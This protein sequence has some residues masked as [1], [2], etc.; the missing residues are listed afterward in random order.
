MQ[1]SSAG[2]LIDS[3]VELFMAR[4]VKIETGLVTPRLSLMASAS[5]NRLNKKS[6]ATCD[7]IHKEPVPLFCSHQGSQQ[8]RIMEMAMN[9][10]PSK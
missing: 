4:P 9:L 7:Q 3:M 10:P 8:W 5:S 2:Y 6:T 1:A